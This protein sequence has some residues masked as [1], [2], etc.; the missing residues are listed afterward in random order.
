MYL[1]ND[2]DGHIHEDWKI[3]R[4]CTSWFT[5]AVKVFTCNITCYL[6]F[7]AGNALFHFWRVC[8]RFLIF[9]RAG[10]KDEPS[11]IRFMAVLVIAIVID[12]AQGCKTPNVLKVIP[13]NVIKVRKTNLERIYL[14][15]R[16]FVVQHVNVV[17]SRQKLVN[18]QLVLGCLVSSNKWGC[19]LWLSWWWQNSQWAWGCLVSNKWDELPCSLQSGPCPFPAQSPEGLEIGHISPFV[20]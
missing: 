15:L 12:M 13:D 1:K 2:D 19:W 18:S 3:L 9:N 4:F 5:F 20:F 6:Y 16:G 11:K 7:C 17:N 10:I 8:M 14:R